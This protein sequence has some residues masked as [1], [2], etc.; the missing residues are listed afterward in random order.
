MAV[1]PADDLRFQPGMALVIGAALLVTLPFIEWLA[2]PEPG[3]HPYTVAGL[4]LGP[5]FGIAAWVAKW[6]G[7]DVWA[8]RICL[9]AGLVASVSSAWSHPDPVPGGLLRPAAA[10]PL[11]VTAVLVPMPIAVAVLGLAGIIT[12]LVVSG[13]DAPADL[14][15][16]LIAHAAAGGLAV[17]ISYG[18]RRARRTTMETSRLEAELARGNFERDA[19]ARFVR[20]A[21]HELRTPLTP[22]RLLPAL[23]RLPKA[24]PEAKEKALHQLERQV[25]RLTAIVDRLGILA[26]LEANKVSFPGDLAKQARLVAAAFPGTEIDAP[27]S[28]PTKAPDSGLRA[29]LQELVTNAHDAAKSHVRV[30]VRPVP[31]GYTV[32]VDDDGPS[33][34]ETMYTR[35]KQ[36]FGRV[37][38]DEHRHDRAGLGLGLVDA[39]AAAVDGHLELGRSDLGGLRATLSLPTASNSQ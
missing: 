10:M 3:F 18:W 4:I 19:V 23:L 13:T 15:P 34:P 38:L 8:Y 1:V 6:P 36:P 35:L 17:A 24:T 30:Q 32:C 9:A 12:T 26:S 2:S 16:Q 25:E 28:A 7:A 20:H 11:L 27:A 21:A 14:W 31:G 29:M 39:M 5:S 22:L 37:Q 33:V